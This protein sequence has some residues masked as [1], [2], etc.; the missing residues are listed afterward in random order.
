MSL[1]L[2]DHP[3]SLINVQKSFP[4]SVIYPETLVGISDSSNHHIVEPC[5]SKGNLQLIVNAKISHLA[6][7]K[8]SS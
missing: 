1:D 8:T 6:L 3:K 2:F 4:I 7:N 5:P